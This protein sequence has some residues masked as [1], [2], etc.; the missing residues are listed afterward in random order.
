MNLKKLK[1][2]LLIP[3]VSLGDVGD[4]LQEVHVDSLGAGG[5]K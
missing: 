5:D 4:R 3:E 1:S 2:V